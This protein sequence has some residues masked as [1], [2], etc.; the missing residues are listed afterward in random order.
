MYFVNF[1]TVVQNLQT[2]LHLNPFHTVMYGLCCAFLNL[3]NS[4]T[5]SASA[6]ASASVEA[7]FLQTDKKSICKTVGS[8]TREFVIVMSGR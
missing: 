3:V 7:R 2:H 6:S 1:L 4:R 8:V 5:P